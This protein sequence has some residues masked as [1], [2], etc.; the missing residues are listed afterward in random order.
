MQREMTPAEAAALAGA[1]NARPGRYG[2]APFDVGRFALV[3]LYDRHAG[4]APSR[5]AI[6]DPARYLDDLER[7]GSAEA[8][9]DPDLREALRGWVTAAAAA[10]ARRDAAR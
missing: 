3:L 2:A 5:C 6:R 4:A 9:D 7:G 8:A 1:I 10:A